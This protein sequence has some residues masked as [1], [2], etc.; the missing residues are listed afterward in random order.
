MSNTINYQ[1]YYN[2]NEWTV[3]EVETE[4]EIA[5]FDENVD[6]SEYCTFLNLGGGF[7]GYTPQFIFNGVDNEDY[8]IE[9]FDINIDF[10]E[11]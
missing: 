11:D 9:N 2:N 1:T 6:A 3:C 4:H 10:I 8:N 7:D 5:H